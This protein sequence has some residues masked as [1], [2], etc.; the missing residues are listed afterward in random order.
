MLVSCI[1]LAGHAPDQGPPPLNSLCS[2]LWMGTASEEGSI[3]PFLGAS[4]EPHIE[5]QRPVAD[6]RG[7]GFGTSLSKMLTLAASVPY[8]NV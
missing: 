1:S 4:R 6:A 8:E 7:G 3:H 2:G 5:Y